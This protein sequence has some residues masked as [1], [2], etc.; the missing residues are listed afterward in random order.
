MNVAE[1]ISIINNNMPNDINESSFVN[2]INILE[3]TIYS[4]FIKIAEKPTPKIKKVESLATDEL[5]LF[6]YGARW[7]LM[8]EYF[9]YGQICI[10]NEEFGKANN[11]LML[12]NSLI[13]EFVQYYYPLI[14]NTVRDSRMRNFR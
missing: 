13:D 2:W 14:E 1:L 8:Y 6:N 9:I 12:Y 3:D 7:V 4:K 10:L 11:Y 5:Y